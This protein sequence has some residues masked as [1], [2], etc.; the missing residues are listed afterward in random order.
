[1]FPGCQGKAWS[2]VLFN[3][4]LSGLMPLMVFAVTGACVFSPVAF[5]PLFDFAGY[6]LLTDLL[7]REIG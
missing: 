1:M 4:H 7:G 6:F 5:L 2:Y 3:F